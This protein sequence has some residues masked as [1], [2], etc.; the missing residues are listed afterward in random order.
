MEMRERDYVLAKLE[1]REVTWME[2]AEETGVSYHWLT[3]FKTGQSP[4]YSRLGLER[5]QKL[6][7]YF[8]KRE[9]KRKERRSA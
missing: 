8:R 5:I 1:E 4:G 7:T 3:K 6:A 9:P 2:L